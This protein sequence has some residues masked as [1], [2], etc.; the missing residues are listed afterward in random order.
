MKWPAN[1]SEF[2]GTGLLPGAL[3]GLLGGLVF[4]ATR[5]EATRLGYLVRIIFAHRFPDDVEVARRSTLLL[6]ANAIQ[7]LI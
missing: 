5:W 6:H 3:A 7:H 1:W 4:G 2:S